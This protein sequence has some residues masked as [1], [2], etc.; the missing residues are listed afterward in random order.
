MK[1]LEPVKTRK[2]FFDGWE[3][4]KVKFTFTCSSC[5]TNA[6]IDFK[7]ILDAAWSWKDKTEAPIKNELAELFGIALT[8]KSIG[9]GMDA[10]VSSKCLNCRQITYTYFWFHEYRNSCYK[11]ALRGSAQSAN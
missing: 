6:S 11:I 10:V 7:N 9:N 4:D 2:P 8:N 1:L 5:G 3:T